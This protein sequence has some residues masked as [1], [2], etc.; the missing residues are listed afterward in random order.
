A[1]ESVRRDADHGVRLPVDVKR[2]ADK[3]AAAAVAFPKPVA[4]HY[5]SHVRIRFAF[6]G[7]IKPAAKRLHAHH[8]EIIFGSQESE[9]APHLVITPDAGDRE[10]ERG[11]I[12]K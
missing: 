1:A 3:I 11:N 9:A 4:C 5:Y 7:V 8:W 12:G 10:L 2:A 6:V